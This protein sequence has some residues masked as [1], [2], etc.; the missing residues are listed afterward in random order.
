M[1]KIKKHITRSTWVQWVVA[2]ALGVL[3]GC[4][5]AFFI[6]SLYISGIVRFGALAAVMISTAGDEAFVMLATMPDAAVQIFGACFVLGVIGG[7]FGDKFA[8]V[9]NLKLCESCRIKVHKREEPTDLR[10]FLHEHVW[11]HIIKLHIPKLFAWLFCTI[12]AINW[13]MA[14]FDLEAIIPQNRLWLLIFAALVGII[15]ESGPHLMFVILFSKG[16]IPFS[17][18]LVNTVSQDGHGLLPLLSYSVEDTVYVQV[19]TTLFALALAVIL[20]L[21]G[22]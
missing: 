10:H 22:F 13:L 7:F 9:L 1:K 4:I 16:L 20:F 19:F 8:E 3:P 15:P 18:L 14:N 6:V 21:L 12:L 11:N 2:S 5:D 17:V